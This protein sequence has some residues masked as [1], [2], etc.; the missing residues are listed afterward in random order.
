MPSLIVILGI[1]LNTITTSGHIFIWNNRQKGSLRVWSKLGRIMYSSGASY[2][3]WD[4]IAEFKTPGVSYHCQVWPHINNSF[5]VLRDP[6][7]Y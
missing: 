3:D 1:T 7:K 5:R 6:S 2:S 4:F